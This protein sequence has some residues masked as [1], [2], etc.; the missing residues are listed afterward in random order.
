MYGIK[1]FCSSSAPVK[2]L[3]TDS[4]GGRYCP[5]ELLSLY[6]EFPVFLAQFRLADPEFSDE[7][8]CLTYIFN[9][10]ELLGPPRS[11]NYIKV[12]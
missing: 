3:A 5:S 6:L 7:Y 12:T 11:L 8:P 9:F 4:W 10:S 2:S 1:N